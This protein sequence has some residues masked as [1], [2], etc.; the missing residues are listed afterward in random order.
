MKYFFLKLR[1]HDFYKLLLTYSTNL[2]IQYIDLN[3]LLRLPLEIDNSVYFEST[4]NSQCKDFY[5][6]LLRHLNLKFKA[7]RIIPKHFLK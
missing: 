6:N 2:Y 1:Y 7:P 5:R 4:I 3:T